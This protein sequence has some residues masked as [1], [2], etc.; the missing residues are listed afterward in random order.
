[1]ARA[2][3]D[4][5]AAEWEDWPGELDTITGYSYDAFRAL[6]R[7][8]ADNPSEI[9]PDDEPMLRQAAI[10]FFG[11]PKMTTTAVEA[12]LGSDWHTALK[13]AFLEDQQ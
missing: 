10:Q 4:D 2:M 1:M 9:K 13:S 8:L 11:Y 12:S 5:V 6:A 7:R 3:L